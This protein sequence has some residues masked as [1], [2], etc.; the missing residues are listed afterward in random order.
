M[1]P[2]TE[3]GIR[4]QQGI[5]Y[6]EGRGTSAQMQGKGQEAEYDQPHWEI[7]EVW[8]PKKEKSC[9][10]EGMQHSPTDRKHKTY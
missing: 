3:M 10:I 2:W 1:L 7:N 8:T 5:E 6:N 9:V 4:G